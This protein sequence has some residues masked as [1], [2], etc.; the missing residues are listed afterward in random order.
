MRGEVNSVQG[1]LSH[2]R[3]AD[4]ER[5]IVLTLISGRV[6]WQLGA[7]YGATVNIYS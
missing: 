5:R 4:M 7:R 6:L 1:S 3:F 2:E